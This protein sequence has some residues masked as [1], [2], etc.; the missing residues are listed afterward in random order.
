MLASAC[1]LAPV[2]ASVCLLA[3]VLAFACLLAS[4]LAFAGFSDVLMLFRLCCL[5]FG[6]LGDSR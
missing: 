6:L 2:L 3:P 1:L 4:V 5:R